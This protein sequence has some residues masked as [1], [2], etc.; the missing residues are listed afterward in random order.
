MRLGRLLSRYASRVTGFSRFDMYFLRIQVLTG[1]IPFPHIKDTAIAHHV[2]H[3]KRPDKP[4]NASSIGFSDSLW[5]FTQ[6]C[7]DGEIESRPEAGEVVTHLV[8]AAANWGGLMSPCVRTVDVASYSGEENSDDC[9][10]DLSAP[11]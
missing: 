4:E 7:W 8:E 11:H 5:D 1:E 6:R 9:E 10:F 3:G 2:L